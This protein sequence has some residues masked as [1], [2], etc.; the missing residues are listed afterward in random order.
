MFS[1]NKLILFAFTQL[2]FFTTWAQTEGLLEILETELNREFKQL[3]KAEIPV[4]YLDYRLNE[5]QTTTIS[6]NMGSLMASGTNKR[7]LLKARVRVGDYSLDNTHEF[8][9]DY[10]GGML[11]GG[12]VENNF[13]PIENKP[14]AIQQSIWFLTH[15]EYLVAADQ[16]KKIQNS[17]RKDSVIVP[18]FSRE[19]PTNYIESES[20]SHEINKKEWE[21]MIKNLSA[22]FL[23]EEDIISGNVDLNY[24]TERVYFVSS[25]GSR[26]V[27]NKTNVFLRIK[28][29]IRGDKNSQFIPLSKTY[30]AFKLEDLPSEEDLI[31][32]IEVLITTL[33]N[34]Q[35]API[36]EPYTGPALLHPRASGVFFHEIFGHRIEGHR[37]K[38]NYDGQTFKEKIDQR[39]LPKSMSVYFEPTRQTYNDQDLIGYYKYDEEGIKARKVTVVENGY[40]KAFLMSR[41]PL[42]NISHSN[43]HGRA[44]AGMAP[45]SRQ[46]NLI[47][48]STKLMD[49]VEL[50]KAFI[51]ECKKQGKEYGYYFVDVQGGY[52][53]TDRYA[54]NAFNIFTHIG[55]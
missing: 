7:R 45:V 38:S 15:M 47:V 40:L 14:E 30:F 23:N 9:D 39:I 1:V 24:T 31:K 33:I 48:E 34:L 27:Q 44:Q 8:E 36:A 16:Y 29:T 13:F 32:D 5:I 21:K 17:N 4:Y 49:S 42:E 19:T 10:F 26:I 20:L 43:G 50:R 52:T 51:K 25:E 55:I 28:G 41:S 18:D 6:S 22:F 46:S 2:I 3:S 54:P 12:G 53:Q 35:Q 11:G 37:L